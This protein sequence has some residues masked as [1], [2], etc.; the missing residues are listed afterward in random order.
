MESLERAQSLVADLAG[1]ARSEL[2]ARTVLFDAHTHLG[3]DIDGMIGDFEELTQLLGAYAFAGAFT[4]C[5][6]EVDRDPA[7]RDANDRTL[8]F[9]ARS[10][11]LLI[12]FV[13]LDLESGP[14]DE[15]RRCLDAGA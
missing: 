8:A 4:F 2:P 11:G 12:P 10:D 3:N 14:L 13:R 5:L 7:F 15:A 1:V 6:D 9:A